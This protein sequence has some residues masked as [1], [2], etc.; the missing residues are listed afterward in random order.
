M[1]A[2][3][4]GQWPDQPAWFCADQLADVG[5]DEDPLVR[6]LLQHLAHEGGLITDLPLAV[7]KTMRGWPAFFA[8]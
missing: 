3:A 5:D 4:S 6:P 7:G 1:P 2:G 8:K